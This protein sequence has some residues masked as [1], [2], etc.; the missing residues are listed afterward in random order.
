MSGNSARVIVGIIGVTG[1]IGRAL[2]VACR[3]RGYVVVGFSRNPGTDEVPLNL[4]APEPMVSRVIAETAERVGEFTAWVNLAGADILSEPVRSMSYEAK[5]NQLWEIDVL[6]SVRCS[7]AILPHLVAD[8]CV[9]NIGWDDACIGHQGTFGELYALTK[10]AVTAYSKSLA[11]TL[12]AS[13]KKVFVFAPGWVSTR[14]HAGLTTQQRDTYTEYITDGAWQT[15]EEVGE[16][17]ADL[18]V[19]RAALDSGT[20]YVL[21]KR[22]S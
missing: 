17:I 22:E 19:G 14:W 8:G 6:G 3:D 12:N 1:G 13:S 5:L 21:P 16:A 2:S 10:A 11:M 20:V 9:I 18:I 4:S 15:P 7:R